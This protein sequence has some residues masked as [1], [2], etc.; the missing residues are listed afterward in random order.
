MS[1]NLYEMPLADLK[2][3][4]IKESMDEAAKAAQAEAIEESNEKRQ[5]HSIGAHLGPGR[6]PDGRFAPKVDDRDILDNNSD[7]DQPTESAPAEPT[8]A[9]PEEREFV[10]RREI[11]LEDGGGT[12]IFTGRGATEREAFEDFAQQLTDA[13]RHAT[14]KLREQQAELRRY[15]Q[16]E[17][18]SN[19]QTAEDINYVTRKQL[20]ENP[21]ETIA[22]VAREAVAKDRMEEIEKLQRSNQVQNDFVAAHP[23]YHADPANGQKLAAWVRTNGFAEFTNENLELAY[24]DLKSSGLLR[25]KSSN[26]EPVEI[27]PTPQ[28]RKRASSVSGRSG[29]SPVVKTEPT[30]DDLYKM[31]LEQLRHLSNRKMEQVAADSANSF[32]STGSY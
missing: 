7:E 29:S 26:A 11:S 19:R 6:S 10:V 4:I 27:L 8:L 5:S 22:R 23:E 21:A 13:Q 3:L 31:P 17:A 30:E 25:L 12:Q 24:Q 18:E 15:H 16:K 28:P 1:Q 2:E 32:G 9:E 14:K 20:E